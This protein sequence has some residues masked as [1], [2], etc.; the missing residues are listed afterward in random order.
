MTRPALMFVAAL[1]VLLAAG[2]AALAQ[3]E[4]FV[5]EHS[6]PAAGG[7]VGVIAYGVP[8]SDDIAIAGRCFAAAGG[9]VELTL[10]VDAS[11]FAPGVEAPVTFRAPGNAALTRTAVVVDSEMFGPHPVLTIPRSDGLMGLLAAARSV[12]VAVFNNPGRTIALGGSA[13]AIG[14]F[15]AICDSIDAEGAVAP[16]AP[17]PAPGLPLAGPLFLAPQQPMPVYANFDGGG[18]LEA[19]PPGTELMGLNVTASFNGEELLQVAT[20]R[21]AGVTGWVPRAMLIPT[22]GGASEY[23]NLNQAANLVLRSGPSST[24]PSVG[25]IPPLARGIFDLGQRSGSY[26]YVRYGDLTGWASHD[27]LA[28]IL[29]PL[30]GGDAQAG[31]GPSADADPAKPPNKD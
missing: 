17:G 25:A 16:A 6:D 28:P 27:Y 14:R 8:Q 5:S 24:A 22:S 18:R 20:L 13:A 2:G 21:G 1:G 4:W 15:N 3:E 23:Q 9:L 7:R 30:A 12:D 31:K 26:V 19:F 29:L 10:Y 11:G